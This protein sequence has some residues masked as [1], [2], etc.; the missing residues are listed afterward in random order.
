MSKKTFSILTLIIIYLIFILDML[1][2]HFFLYWRF[3]WFDIVMHFLG[4]F[5]VAF[6][7]Y[8][9]FYFSGYFKKITKKF[10][11]FTLS[12]VTLI[13]VGVLWEVFEYLTKV[14]LNQLNYILDTSLDLLMDVIGWLPAYLILFRIDKIKKNKV[15]EEA[16]DVIIN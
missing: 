16:K 5:W 13:L 7:T 10:S 1:A 4:G 14:S 2:S 3:W 15:V 6:A 12:L 9:L 8:Y 11:L